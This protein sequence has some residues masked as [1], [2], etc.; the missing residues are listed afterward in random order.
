MLCLCYLLSSLDGSIMQFLNLYCGYATIYSDPN[1][2]RSNE[3]LGSV[4]LKT[5]ARAKIP[6]FDKEAKKDLGLP[7]FERKLFPN[8]KKVR[9]GSFVSVYCGKIEGKSEHAVTNKDKRRVH[10]FEISKF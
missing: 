3:P 4:L 1:E 6:N 2:N 5:E 10:L 8:E 9:L 7:K